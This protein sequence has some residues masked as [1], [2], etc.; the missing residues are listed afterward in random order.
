MGKQQ[1]GQIEQDPH[2]GKYTVIDSRYASVA[3]QTT[4]LRLAESVCALV[5]ACK[6]DRPYDLLWHKHEQKSKP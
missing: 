3:I 5:N 6:H 2:T 4:E 1:R